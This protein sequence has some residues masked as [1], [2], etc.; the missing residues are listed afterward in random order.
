VS[1]GTLGGKG[2]IGGAVSVL[3]GTLAPG[4]GPDDVASIV[5]FTLTTGNVLNTG[6]V[7]MGPAASS[8]PRSEATPTTRSSMPPDRSS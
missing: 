4:L 2:T 7:K 1:G 8:P 5:G 3:G 6:P